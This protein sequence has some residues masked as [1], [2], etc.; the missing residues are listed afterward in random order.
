MI[1]FTHIDSIL[2]YDQNTSRRRKRRKGRKEGRDDEPGSRVITHAP[3]STSVYIYPRL[4]APGLCAINSLLSHNN[5]YFALPK[6][7][8][9]V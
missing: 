2:K 7:P 9:E 5:R 6:L 4:R 8:L 3:V 1:I